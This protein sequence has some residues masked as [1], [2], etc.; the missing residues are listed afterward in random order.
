M[1]KVAG[2]MLPAT[3]CQDVSFIDISSI[4]SYA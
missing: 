3:H 1:E 4:D 2:Q